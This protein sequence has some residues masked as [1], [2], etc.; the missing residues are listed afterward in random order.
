[1]GVCVA[2]RRECGGMRGRVCEACSEEK[3][4]WMYV[5]ACVCVCEACTSCLLC[6][7][8]FCPVKCI[9]KPSINAIT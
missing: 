7:P 3:G 4:V 6:G 9:F 8:H 5:W 1:M 2:K